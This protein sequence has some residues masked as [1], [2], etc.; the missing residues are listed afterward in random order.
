LSSLPGSID[1]RLWESISG[2]LIRPLKEVEFPLEGANL[3]KGIISY[4]TRKHEGNV[5]DKGIVAIASKS[6]SSGYVEDVADLSSDSYFM[7][8]NEPD[9]WIRWDFHEIRVRPTDYTIRS[10]R[11]ESWVVEGSLD[12][13]N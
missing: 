12:F 2:R 3:F 10:C 9:Q 11:L 5:H 1:P 13:V 6:I 7:S 8:S 4:H